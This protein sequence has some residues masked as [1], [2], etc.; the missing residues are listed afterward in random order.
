MSSERVADLIAELREMADMGM[1]SSVL[2]EAADEI[3]RL[4]AALTEIA[5]GNDLTYVFTAGD[6]ERAI[7]LADPAGFARHILAEG[8]DQ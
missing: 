8:S 5:N 4:R 3:E 7:K 1:E 6:G 2:R